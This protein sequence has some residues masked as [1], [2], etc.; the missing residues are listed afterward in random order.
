MSWPLLHSRAPLCLSAATAV[1][2]RPTQSPMPTSGAGS[3]LPATPG[4]VRYSDLVD[5][6][7]AAGQMLVA[8]RGI[9]H[10]VS[11]AERAAIEAMEAAVAAVGRE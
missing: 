7:A 11:W 8:I 3:Q 6:A 4:T 5:A 10:Q 1:P 2:R 9:L